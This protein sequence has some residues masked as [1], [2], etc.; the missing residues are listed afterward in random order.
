MMAQFLG[1]IQHIIRLSA[2]IFD[3]YFSLM[4]GMIFPFGPIEESEVQ[5]LLKLSSYAGFGPINFT[6]VVEKRLLKINPVLNYPEQE[7]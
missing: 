7:N 1:G 5:Y 6:E 4:P 3:S 2:M